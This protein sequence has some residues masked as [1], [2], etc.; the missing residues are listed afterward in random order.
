M[1]IAENTFDRA[2]RRVENARKQKSK[3][4][5]FG[6][7]RNLK[8]LP[9]LSGLPEVLEINLS[10]IP[11][12]DLSPIAECSSLQRLFLGNTPVEDLAPIANIA[13]LNE[14]YLHNTQV[15]SIYALSKLENLNVLT[16]SETFVSDISHLRSLKNLKWID[17]KNTK[18]SSLFGLS[19]LTSI[20]WLRLNSTAISELMPIAKAQSLIR[21]DISDTQV[22][23]LSPL[24]ELPSLQF[25]VGD[26]TKIFD[27]RP[28]EK[29]KR[30]NFLSLQK[31][32]VA[33]LA[34][35]AYLTNLHSLNVSSTRISD[36]APVA[37][38]IQLTQRIRRPAPYG[39][40]Y[41]RYQYYGLY[42]FSF[43]KSW[44]DDQ[45]NR[46]I[47]R[48]D[49]W[50]ESGLS[51]ADC[52]LADPILQ[53]F[54]RLPNPERSVATVD[55]IRRLQNLP[56]VQEIG[57]RISQRDLFSENIDNPQPVKNVTSPYAFELSAAGTIVLTSSAVNWPVF[58]LR[59][60]EKDH[61]NRL[62]VCRKLS[63]DLV[64]DLRQGKFQVREQYRNGLEQYGS[65]LPVGPGDGNVLLAD[66]E[67][68]TL[69][70]LFAAEA[71]ILP[72]AFSSK[73]KTFLEQHIGLRVFYPEI[74]NF[75]RD[76][77]RGRI[78]DPL[79]LDAVA[80]VVQGVR[81]NTPT[82]FAPSV[83]EA[84]EGS[85][86]PAS[87]SPPNEGGR[88][89]ASEGD[90]PLPPRDPLGEVDSQKAG[91]FTFAGTANGL[92]KA[93]IEGNKI[94]K[95]AEAWQK[96]GDALR[97]HINEILIW[98]QRFL[99]TTGGPPPPPTIGV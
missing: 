14:L 42:P 65:R 79:P 75:Y 81:D 56:P 94:H 44:D 76:V 78:E 84:I 27:L 37:N 30:L 57:G 54:A 15:S 17:L 13:S 19:D 16:L 86:E 34:P 18:V 31:T 51:F 39:G 32:F 92:W 67:A 36:L 71:D 52:R 96:T 68:R 60:S 41:G 25:I 87:T 64:G 83:Q 35:L 95:A 28:L 91:D 26:R 48:A 20:E 69:R 45:S 6:D 72:V 8:R 55:Y 12:S 40:R 90:L 2:S 33:D 59:T 3:R 85:A 21:L 93:F 74:A 23:D 5:G 22:A 50:L 80:G 24:S 77:Q 97:P 1:S 61:A 46:G 66:A 47:S 88:G 62:D 49:T 70:N 53:E 82:V 29:L 43:T 73:L 11:I 89:L 98:L 58:P 4:I 9:D 38:L 63:E 7:L 10:G 99:N